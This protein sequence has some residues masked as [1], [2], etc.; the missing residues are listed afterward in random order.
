M[1]EHS[2]KVHKIWHKFEKFL[3]SNYGE[4]FHSKLSGYDV[5]KNIE[6]FVEN[7]CPEIKIV[8]CDDEVFASSILVLVPHPKM[9]ITILFIPQ[10]TTIGNHFFLYESHFKSFTKEL[11]KMKKVY[12]GS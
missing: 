12:K 5:Q 10:C 6:K 8:N 1:I 9:G 7:K 4:N 2:M 3:I 11:D